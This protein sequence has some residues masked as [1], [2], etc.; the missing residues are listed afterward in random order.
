MWTSLMRSRARC[1]PAKV[2][3]HCLSRGHR[4]TRPRRR[5]PTHRRVA[6]HTG[7]DGNPLGPAPADTART[8]V[9][10]FFLAFDANLEIIPIL[11]KVDLAV[12]D[13]EKCL[14]D[15]QRTFEMDPAKVLRIS[16]KTGL[17][18]DKVLPAV[19]ERVPPYVDHRNAQHTYRRNTGSQR[20]CG[21][22]TTSHCIIRTPHD[23]TD[24]SLHTLRAPREP[25][26]LRPLTAAPAVQRATRSSHSRRCSSTIGT[27][28]TRASSA[29]SA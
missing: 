5:H 4:V 6:R 29:S 13:T 11:S 26:G 21:Q 2:R 25:L 28:R 24:N 18:L 19:I 7:T 1:A 16:A 14:E 27:R 3:C 10:N 23:T 12:A 17:N 15:V 9:S 22:Y 8:Q 20:H